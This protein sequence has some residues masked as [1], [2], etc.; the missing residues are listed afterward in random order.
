[1]KFGLNEEIFNKIE[2][3]NL[4]YLVQER[5]EHIKISQILI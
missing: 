2:N 5:M 1:M 3:I 4:K